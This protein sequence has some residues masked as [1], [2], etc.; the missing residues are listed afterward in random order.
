[1][2]FPTGRAQ[3]PT[4]SQMFTSCAVQFFVCV[5]IHLRMCKSGKIEN[6][7]LRAKLEGIVTRPTPMPS[8][9]CAANK[10]I[11]PGYQ[12]RPDATT[13]TMTDVSS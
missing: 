12:G 1:M 2:L 7:W 11:C 10:S 3:L 4:A 9:S 13:A 5:E 8:L 6:N